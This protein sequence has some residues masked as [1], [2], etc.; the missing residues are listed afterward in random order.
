MENHNRFL[1]LHRDNS[2]PIFDYQYSLI[3]TLEEAVEKIIQLVPQVIDHMMIAKEKCSRHSPLLTHDE[4]A[5]IYLYTMPGSFFSSLNIALRNQDR[6]QLQHWY[7][8]LQL[9]IT[10]VKKLPSTKATI[11]R[12]VNFDDTH[13]W[14]GVSSCSMDPY[15]VEKYIA[16]GSTLFVI[17][18]INTKDISTFSALPEEQEVVLIP[19]TCVRR[20]YGNLNF[21][22]RLFVIHLEEINLVK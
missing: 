16:E 22:D 9:F 1:E 5:A 3:L 12:E 14:W 13:I 21:I 2:R 7:A 17:D 4:S 19:G 18:A 10:A 6:I 11:W 8:F 15:V 20:R